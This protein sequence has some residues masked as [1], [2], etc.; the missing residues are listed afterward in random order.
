MST[1]S[2]QLC[3]SSVLVNE[4]KV[5]HEVSIDNHHHAFPSTMI[6]DSDQECAEI[7]IPG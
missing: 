1:I 2:L 6:V 4:L 5:L 7:E 3:V